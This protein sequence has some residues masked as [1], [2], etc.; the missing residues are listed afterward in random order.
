MR[1]NLLGELT[2]RPGQRLQSLSSDDLDA[3]AARARR[4][5]TMR[6]DLERWRW[7]TDGFLAITPGDPTLVGDMRIT[8]KGGGFSPLWGLELRMGESPE[9]AW[10]NRRSNVDTGLL[11][12]ELLGRNPGHRTIGSSE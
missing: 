7:F 1:A 4:P 3:I 9:I 11:W 2:Y 10:G 5:K 8:G 12:N 6:G